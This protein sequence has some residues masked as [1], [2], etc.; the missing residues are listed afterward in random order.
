M[1]YHSEINQ[2]NICAI[3]TPAGYGG[4]AIIRISGKDSISIVNS[5]FTRD[6]INATGY[7]LKFGTIKHENLEIDQVMVSIY[8]S[9]K[10]FTGEDVVEIACHGSIYIQH[11]IIEIL[12]EKKVRLAKA[13][14]FSQRAFLNGKMDL[15][16]TEAVADLIYAKSESAHQIALNQMKGSFTNELSMLRDKLIELAS[17]VELELD[18]AEED[19]DFADKSQL[20]M[21]IDEIITRLIDLKQSFSYGNAIKNGVPVV[22]IGKPNAGKSTLLNKII[23]EE[24]ALVS[25]IPGTTRDT[26]EESFV[27]E[28]IE[29]RFIDTAGIRDTIDTVEK[30]GV[31]R[32]LE[33]AKK[34]SILIY[35]YDASEINN[36]EVEN[37]IL[38][39]KKNGIPIITIANKIDL[40][41]KNNLLG[42]L[43]I[44]ANNLN[45]VEMVKKHILKLF[46][47]I[48]ETYEGTI[49]TNSRHLEAINLCLSDLNKVKEGLINN[50]SGEF[51]AMDIRQSLHQL[52]TITGEIS[53]EEL[54]GNIF[55]NFCIGK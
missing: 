45:D 15:T 32:S 51:L 41:Q 33:M 38:N 20:K 3:S 37:D 13:G 6:I 18:F 11:K 55:A 8:R 7:T 19:V 14:E 46:L 48:G 44:S 22:I 10:S 47:K 2:D 34:A 39:F 24:R 21:L 23:K 12:H 1:M 36:K 53:T 16:Q 29:F 5:I 25:N 17:L 30:M 50:T 52:G 28:G 54:L 43:H 49:L 26:I 9:P 31:N 4:V 27:I 40:I 42:D 35:L